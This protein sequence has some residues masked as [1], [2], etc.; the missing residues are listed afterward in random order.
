ML[1]SLTMSCIVQIR[2][3]FHLWFNSGL[4]F[5]AHGQLSSCVF[6]HTNPFATTSVAEEKEIDRYMHVHME[7]R[8]LF[9]HTRPATTYSLE[10]SMFFLLYTGG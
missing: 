3:T 7:E 10:I 1:C 8:A 2:R 5:Q 4:K 9:M 6:K